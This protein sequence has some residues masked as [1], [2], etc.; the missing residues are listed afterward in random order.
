MMTINY[1][2]NKNTVIILV[3]FL[4]VLTPVSIL[5]FQLDKG[6]IDYDVLF[7]ESLKRSGKILNLS[8]KKIGDEG[9]E[10]LVSSKYLEKVKKIDL[11]YN[12][13]TAVGAQV[14]AKM[15]PLPKLRSLILRHN[16]LGDAGVTALAKSDSFPNLEEMQLGWTETRDAGAL[17]FGSTNKFQNLKKLDLRGNFLANGTKEELKKSLSHLKILKL[18]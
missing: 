18:F 4:L 1:F 5:G 2:Y 10:H 13:I 8:G 15:S 14:L 16:I 11:R 12:E 6:P 7:K 9:I 17:A 3:S